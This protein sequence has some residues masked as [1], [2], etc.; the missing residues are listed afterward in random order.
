MMKKK[1]VLGRCWLFNY[2]AHSYWGS[3]ITK[4]RIQGKVHQQKIFK[5]KVQLERPSEGKY[6]RRVFKR[7]SKTK[8]FK[9]QVQ[10]RTL[11]GK[12]NRRDL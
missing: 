1:G 10:Q 12:F 9:G 2:P 6:D 5:G 3:P 4:L 11:K 7:D 8:N